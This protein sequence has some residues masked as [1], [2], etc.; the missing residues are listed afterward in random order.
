MKS[1]LHIVWLGA[2]LALSGCE[3]TVPVSTGQPTTTTAA[4]ATTGPATTTASAKPSASAP[5]DGPLAK[6]PYL[7]EMETPADNALTQSKI[8]LGKILFFDKRL[9]LDQKFACENCH[10]V[11][12]GWADALP[13]STKADGKNNSRH[14]PALHNVGY[15]KSWYWDGRSATLEVQ[16][17]AAWKG[18][19]GAD[20]DKV[21]AELAKV[22]EYGKRFKEA[23]DKDD[24]TPDDVVK[25]L[26]SFVRSVR[27]GDAP[28][29]K[30][31]QGDKKAMSES[32]ARGWEIFRN[33]AA[34]ARCH[35]PPL[36]T[37]LDFHNVGVG[38]DK[39][40]PDLGRFN[41]TKDDK[42]KGKFKTPSL[43]SV[44]KH[45][46][47]FHDGSAAT[48]EAAVDYMLSGGHQNDNM[49]ENLKKVELT[50]EEKADLLAFLQ[51][52]DGDQPFEPAKVP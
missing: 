35:A 41:V 19:M 1:T 32:A 48:L 38:M 3:E 16:V 21:V 37:D 14:T 36:F 50:P 52:L 5:A 4:P 7:P 6:L 22:D 12:K 28:F 18:Q 49:D 34:C 23:F 10:F 43:R 47:Y 8:D 15:Q 20:P 31:E 40:E 46:P 13:V 30:F 2:A 11:D 26:A 33:K 45:P 51:A 39:P 42:D 27:S 24:I 17:L 29:D 9:G 25:A 44:S